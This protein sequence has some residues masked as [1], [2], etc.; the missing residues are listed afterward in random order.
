VRRA[1]LEELTAAA[2]PAA[3][4][5]VHEHYRAPSGAPAGQE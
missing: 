4:R 1:S 2:G 3:A 5:K